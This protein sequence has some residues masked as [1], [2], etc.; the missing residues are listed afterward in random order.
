MF[1][2]GVFGGGGGCLSGPRGVLG[3]S[4]VV[5]RRQGVSAYFQGCLRVSVSV[6][7][8]LCLLMSVDAPFTI[9][10]ESGISII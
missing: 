1:V 2:I 3:V 9:G 8:C 4:R 5:K 6:G 10:N 7:V